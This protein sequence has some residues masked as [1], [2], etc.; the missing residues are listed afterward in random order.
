[1]HHRLFYQE[2]PAK[3]DNQHQY[4]IFQILFEIKIYLS[5]KKVYL[6]VQLF[7]ILFSVC[8]YVL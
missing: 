2:I 8:L 4:F 3:C 5:I 7:F 6:K 1:M